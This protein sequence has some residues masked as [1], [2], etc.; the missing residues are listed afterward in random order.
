MFKHPLLRY[1]GTLCWAF[2]LANGLAHVHT[3]LT[4]S[5]R[6][7]SLSLVSAKAGGPFV[8]DSRWSP[9]KYQKAEIT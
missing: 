6:A 1:R 9:D 3:L 2:C 5:G 4:K 7:P 8:K